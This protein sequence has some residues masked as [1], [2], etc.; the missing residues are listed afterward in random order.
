M[1]SRFDQAFTLVRNEQKKAKERD[2]QY[3]NQ[4][5]RDHHYERGQLVYLYT[6]SKGK[7][8]SCWEGPY[9]IIKVHQ[10]NLEIKSIHNPKDIQTVHV[11]RV[12]PAYIRED[13]KNET[14]DPDQYEIEWILDKKITPY[15]NEYKVRW[16]GFTKRYDQWVKEQD[17]NAPEL[18]KRFEWTKSQHKIQHSEEKGEREREL[19]D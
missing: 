8:I 18:I 11:S 10:V 12:K 17:I 3:Y 15:G 13:W 4:N 14:I 7:F 5:R 2:V 6:P 19:S 1:L 16:K 9:R